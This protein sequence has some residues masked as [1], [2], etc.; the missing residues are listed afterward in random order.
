MPVHPNSLRCLGFARGGKLPTIYTGTNL[1]AW[2]W[3]YR[4]ETGKLWK[5]S[6]FFPRQLKAYIT[7]ILRADNQQPVLTARVMY[8]GD[9]RLFL[10]FYTEVKLADCYR[11]LYMC[12]VR[13]TYKSQRLIPF[14]YFLPF[15]FFLCS[16]SWT[17]LP[18]TTRTNSLATNTY[19]SLTIKLNVFNFWA[20]KRKA[21]QR[22]CCSLISFAARFTQTF[23]IW[24]WSC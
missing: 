11:Y 24:L 15:C 22:E 13:Y 1:Y 19:T 18:H 2:P 16:K 9:Y 10:I 6:G 14:L 5:W 23:I 17:P 7:V 21:F 12:I 20:E 8:L 3:G 4:G